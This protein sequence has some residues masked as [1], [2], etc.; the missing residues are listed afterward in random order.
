MKRT[1]LLSLISF[2]L[3]RPTALLAVPAYPAKRVVTMS[4]GT[5]QTLTLTGDEYC[6][7]WLSEQGHPMQRQADGTYRRLS[8]FELENVIAEGR[9]QRISNNARM[10]RRRVNIGDFVPF[11]GKKKGLV[12]LVNFADNTFSTDDPK[13]I[14]NDFFNKRGYTDFGMT[15]SVSDYFIAQSYGKFELDF[16][17]VGP[18]TLSKPMAAYGAPNDN[19]HDCDPYSMASEACLAAN[20]EVDYADYDWDRDGVVDQVFI[21]YAGYAEAQGADENTIWPHA[22]RLDGSMKLDG[23]AIMRYAC[24]CELRGNR[25][26]A[27]D[28]IGTACHEFSHCLGLPDVYDVDYN[29]GF[30]MSYWDLMDSGAYTNDSRTPT[31]YTSYE[32]WMVGWLTPTEL[33]GDEQQVTGLKPIA[34][35]PEAYI[36]YNDANHNEYYLLENRQPVGFDAGLTG[37]GMLVLHVDYNSDAWNSNRINT[38]AKH[39]RMSIIP[40]DN[41]YGVSYASFDGDPFPGR[42]GATAL[43][44]VSTPAATLFNPNTDGEL[45]MHKAIERITED[46]NGLISFL[47]LRKLLATPEPRIGEVGRTSFSATWPAVPLATGYEVELVETPSKREPS[48]ALT[49][50]EDFQGCYAAKA[51]FSDVGIKL[52]ALLKTQG[53]KGDKLYQTPDLLRFGTSTAN[54]F[55]RSPTQ[56]A[57]STAELTIVLRLK[58]FAEGSEVIGNVH[59]VTNGKGIEEIPFA[60]STEQYIVLHP[61]MVLDEIFQVRIYPQSRMYINYLALY[62]GAFSEEELGLSAPVKSAAP[63]RVI[64]T[65]HTSNTNTYTFSNLNPTS[66]Y[67]FAVRATDSERFSAWSETINVTLDPN[68]VPQLPVATPWASDR[69]YDLNGRLIERP[70]QPGIFIRGGKK[71]IRK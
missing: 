67:A 6:H 48:E 39:Q 11:S 42:T 62:D 38:D 54:G 16:D 49:L 9:E 14:Y 32:R 26:T 21:I 70:S 41:H 52:D 4:D 37:Q 51:G 13:A 45:F 44:D 5:R 47:A 36:L 61:K 19:S 60:F 63:R 8:T 66:K 64:S 3:L 46:E 17:V 2:A 68:D 28:G 12:I 33:T 20:A 56:S 30:G 1:I 71:F 50:V 55:L 31:G 58:P 22:S 69:V 65:T 34:E 43:T 18:Y 15:G 35:A 23:R 59:V 29:G 27:L 25:G 24:T 53:F 57:L 10:A 40:A 7:Y